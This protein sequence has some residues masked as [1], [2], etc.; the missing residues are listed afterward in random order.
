M[1]EIAQEYQGAEDLIFRGILDPFENAMKA[2]DCLS[3]KMHITQTYTISGDCPVKNI[4]CR[5]EREEA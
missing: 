2:L 1:G 4:R 5:G 3:R